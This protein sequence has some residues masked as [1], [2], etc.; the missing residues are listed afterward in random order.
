MRGFCRRRGAD[1][2]HHTAPPC[3]DAQLV[4]LCNIA[5]ATRLGTHGMRV[6]RVSLSQKLNDTDHHTRAPPPPTHPKPRKKNKNR[7]ERWDG[8]DCNVCFNVG[9]SGS[10]SLERA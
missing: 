7:K 3:T 1:V 5:A 8:W 6:D 4:T 9:Q 10:V 2:S